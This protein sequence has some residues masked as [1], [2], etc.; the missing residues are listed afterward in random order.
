MKNDYYV[1]PYLIV[2]KLNEG[3]FNKLLNEHQNIASCGLGEHRMLYKNGKDFVVV[4]NIK[5][6]N[7]R[8][9]NISHDTDNYVTKIDVRDIIKEQSKMDLLLRPF[10]NDVYAHGGFVAQEWGILNGFW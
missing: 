1:G 5:V 4:P 9:P 10:I 7:N 2:Y 6:C 3:Q 8:N